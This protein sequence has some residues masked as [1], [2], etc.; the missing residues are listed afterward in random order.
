MIL[1]LGTMACITLYSIFFNFLG[2]EKDNHPKQ[3]FEEIIEGFKYIASEKGLLAIACYFGFS[4]MAGGLTTA[5]NERMVLMLLMGINL[6]AAIF[7]IGANRRHVK[8]I[9]NTTN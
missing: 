2:T 3:M 6:L 1:W 4:A 9:Y 8:V 7:I 5:L